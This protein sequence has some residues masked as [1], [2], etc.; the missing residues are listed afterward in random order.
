MGGIFFILVGYKDNH[1]IWDEFELWPDSTKDCGV[2]LAA[3][4]HLKTNPI[5]L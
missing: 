5:Y 1:N 2:I 3:L 4:E